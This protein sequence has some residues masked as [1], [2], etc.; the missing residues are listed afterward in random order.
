M[1]E[2]KGSTTLDY[3]WYRFGVV[4]VVGWNLGCGDAAPQPP[5]ATGATTPSEGTTPA[6]AAAVA[7]NGMGFEVSI[8]GWTESIDAKA[9]LNVTEEIGRASCRERV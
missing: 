7:A 4:A 8:E 6:G 5:A 1:A 2:A 9:Q 3:M